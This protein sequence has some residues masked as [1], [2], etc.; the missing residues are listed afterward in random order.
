MKNGLFPRAGKDLQPKH[1][2]KGPAGGG[3]FPSRSREDGLP[4]AFLR[5][6][7]LGQAGNAL[8]SDNLDLK[9]FRSD[10]EKSPPAPL[11]TTRAPRSP[12]RGRPLSA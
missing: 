6:L 12:G 7:L 3:P 5:R 8:A 10:K 1:T 4:F 11:L 9:I 2:Q